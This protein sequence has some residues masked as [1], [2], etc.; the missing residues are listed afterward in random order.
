MFRMRALNSVG[1]QSQSAPLDFGEARSVVGLALPQSQ[2]GD[3]KREHNGPTTDEKSLP[4]SDGAYRLC[5]WS[6]AA[7]NS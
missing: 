2:T 5:R 3:S 7:R 1:A 4:G 6:P